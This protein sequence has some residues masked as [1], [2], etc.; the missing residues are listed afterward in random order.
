M[1]NSMY[2]YQGLCG[3]A[4]AHRATPMAGHLGAALIAGYFLGEDLRDMDE[5]VWAG[6]AG[7]LDRILNGEETVWFDPQEAGITIDELFAPVPDESPREGGI[8]AIA[9]ALSGN[10]G[11]TRQSGHNAIFA[12]I[13]IRALHDHT[14]L[15]T[16]IILDGIRRLIEGFDNASP[17]R[18]YYGKERGWIEGDKVRLESSNEP[19]VY[20]D[21]AELAETAIDELI[22]GASLPRRGFGG[23]VHV[24]NHAAA[25]VELSRYGYGNLARSGFP[26]HRH[27]VR[28]WRSLPSIEDELGFAEPAECDP[29]TPEY[30]TTGTFRRDSARL[31]HR[32][33]S[34]YGFITLTRFIQDRAERR[35]A[36]Q[37]FLYLM[38]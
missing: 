9:E 38:A 6:I 27:H 13:A 14:Q 28:L 3:L 16:P 12:A 31:T 1:I 7:E 35:A 2:L 36:E 8:P 10:V 34:L 5:R 30:W 22:Q 25:L 37:Q 17:G 33:K 26:A 32:I 24:I 11:L 18:G 21:E 20:T 23:L 4:R 19:S 29:R 15:A